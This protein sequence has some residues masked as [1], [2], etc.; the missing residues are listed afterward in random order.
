MTPKTV[1]PYNQANTSK[2]QE[3]TEM[4]DT[5]AGRYDLLNHLLSMGIDKL[6]RRKAMR[7]LA[8]NQP[9]MILDIATGTAD[10]AIAATRLAPKSIIGLDI[11]ANMIELASAKV[12]K[13]H[14]ADVISVEVGDSE[15]LRFKNETFDA[16]MVGF[17][18]R[19][20]GDLEAGLSEMLRVTKPGGT[21]L[22]LEFS[23]PKKFPVKQ[24]FAFY[25]KYFIPFIGRTISKDARAYSYLPESV[26]AFPEGQ[27]F[28]SI[29]IKIGYKDV[30]A[31]FVSGGIA[32]IY[33]GIK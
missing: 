23:K 8:K 32:T 27:S 18:V 4:F 33:T 10:L 20:F 17:G 14:L 19:N 12:A 11:S 28:L 2:K 30:D 29:L 21:V 13:K 15:A 1:K 3:V 9:K 24:S 16:V 22:I 31:T 5:I 26:A 6:W 25:S 7:I